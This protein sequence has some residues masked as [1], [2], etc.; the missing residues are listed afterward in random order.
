MSWKRE[1]KVLANRSAPLADIRSCNAN[2]GYYKSLMSVNAGSITRFGECLRVTEVHGEQVR[3][4]KANIV[5]SELMWT[6][7]SCAFDF[8][9]ISGIMNL[10][11]EF[12]W[13]S[14]IVTLNQQNTHMIITYKIMFCRDEH[15]Y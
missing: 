1:Y 3:T 9:T 7:I 4:D 11:F 10:N 8:N 6:L 5:L 13:Y 2:T 15:V 14:H 12:I